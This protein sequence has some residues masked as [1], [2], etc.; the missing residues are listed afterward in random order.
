MAD[1]VVDIEDETLKNDYYRKI[2]YTS[3]DMQ[4]TL[5]SL[6]P[7]QEIGIEQHNGDQFIRIEKGVGELT[8]GNNVYE[9]KDDVAFIIPAN[10]N[11]NVVNTS[12]DQE[13]KLYSIYSPPQHS[14]EDNEKYK[15]TT[16]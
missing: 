16:I 15:I 5:M 10:T 3:N 13:L 11:H 8:I 6:L 1:L 2:L 9:L 12:Y 4:L 7:R 14:H